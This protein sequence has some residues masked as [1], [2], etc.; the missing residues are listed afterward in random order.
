MFVFNLILFDLIVNQKKIVY[1][2]NHNISPSFHEIESFLNEYWMKYDAAK[3][4]HPDDITFRYGRGTSSEQCITAK[5]KT[6]RQ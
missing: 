3:T 5:H 6:S 1:L 4:R 2:Q